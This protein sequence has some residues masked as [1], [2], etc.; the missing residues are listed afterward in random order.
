MVGSLRRSRE[1]DG[2]V[3]VGAAISTEWHRRGNRPERHHGVKYN[4]AR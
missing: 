1:F 2:G 3:D 4:W